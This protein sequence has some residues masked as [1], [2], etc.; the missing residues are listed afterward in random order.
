MKAVIVLSG[1]MDSTTLLFKARSMGYEIK[2]VTIDYGQRHLKEIGFAKRICEE[3][4][5]EH[6][7]ADLSRISPLLAG[8][9]QTSQEIEVPEG[10]YAEESMKLTVVPNRNMILLSIAVGWAVSLKFDLVG[11]AAH[12]GDHT[13]YPDCRPEFVQALNSAV[14]LCDWH[15]VGLWAPFL[16]MGKEDIVAEGSG[17]DVPWRKTWS[18]Y[19]GLDLH[20]GKCG[21]CVER[22]EAFDLAGVLDPT[23]YEPE[24]PR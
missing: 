6:R 9:S 23:D 14:A 10:H 1:G 12:A 16:D 17:Y 19:K 18:C 2:A 24:D 5:I 8:S 13:V 20:C 21:T 4:G 15:K 7:V 3:L 11:Y 22:R